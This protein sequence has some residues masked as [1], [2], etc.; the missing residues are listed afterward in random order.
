MGEGERIDMEIW[1]VGRG[2]GDE[3]DE[4]WMGGS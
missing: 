3:C 4:I 2:V 1:L